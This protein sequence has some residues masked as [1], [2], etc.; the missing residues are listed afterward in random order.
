MH[1]DLADV[2]TATAAVDP[3]LTQAGLPYAARTVADR[4]VG[5]P[6]WVERGSVA[7]GASD[8]QAEEVAQAAHG[9]VVDN[10]EIRLRAPAGPRPVRRGR[11]AAVVRPE[12]RASPPRGHR[13]L[14][15]ARTLPIEEIVPASRRLLLGGPPPRL[16][17]ST[18]DLLRR[19]DALG[20][21]R[22]VA[23]AAAG[24]LIHP[25][26]GELLPVVVTAESVVR[27]KSAPDAYGGRKAGLAVALPDVGGECGWSASAPLVH[28]VAVPGGR[29]ARRRSGV[30][31]RKG[32]IR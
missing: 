27:G 6:G 20:L 16:I 11:R 8:A 32:R 22:A 31:G 5:H 9:T 29:S 13:R 23:S 21:P 26:L 19:A 14:A 4:V 12:R 1:Y 15:G 18:V 7:F 10:A 17:D 3:G 28:E 2:F 30:R 25:G 24:V